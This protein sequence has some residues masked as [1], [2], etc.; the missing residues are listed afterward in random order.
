LHEDN[1]FKDQKKEDLKSKCHYREKYNK[2]ELHPSYVQKMKRY[3][4]NKKRLQKKKEKA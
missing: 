2:N 4:K 1:T 3:V